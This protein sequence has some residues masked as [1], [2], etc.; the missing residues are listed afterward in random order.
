MNNEEKIYVLLTFVMASLIGGLGIGIVILII[1]FI[2]DQVS[3]RSNRINEKAVHGKVFIKSAKA[4][5]IKNSCMQRFSPPNEYTIYECG[6]MFPSEM[7]AEKQEDA[8]L[9]IRMLW[10]AQHVGSYSSG[11]TACQIVCQIAIYSVELS[12]NI[13]VFNFS[14]S[15]PPD[16]I[17]NYG[18]YNRRVYDDVYGSHPT[19]EIKKHFLEIKELIKKNSLGQ[20]VDLPV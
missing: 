15:S 2:I 6:K 14:G 12:K 4:N 19:E 17:H 13:E 1:V 8:N 20:D 3:K 18:S 9:I 10:W 16:K 5:N 7:R 11:N